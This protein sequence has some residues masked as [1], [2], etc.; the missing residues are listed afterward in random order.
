MFFINLNAIL[1]VS[2]PLLGHIFYL[3]SD[4]K[5]KRYKKKQRMKKK[6]NNICYRYSEVGHGFLSIGAPEV[7]LQ[8]LDFISQ[9]LT[10]AFVNC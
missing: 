5:Y 10:N 7:A 1:F 3:V 2:S 8:A 4:S 6:N 9:W